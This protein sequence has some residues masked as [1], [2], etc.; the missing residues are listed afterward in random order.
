MA[1]SFMLIFITLEKKLCFVQCNAGM[2]GS[3][4]ALVYVSI[5]SCY[6]DHYY[7]CSC[8]LH[9]CVARLSCL[10][11]SWCI[12]IYEFAGAEL[13]PEQMS[14]HIVSL[15]FPPFASC[16]SF[17]K[18]RW[19]RVQSYIALRN[20]RMPFYVLLRYCISYIC[21]VFTFNMNFMSCCP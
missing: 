8:W 10:L 3:D 11:V 19:L 7:C 20:R 13:Q 15:F 4:I 18:V 2:D 16:Y 9:N 14:V 17:C 1:C 5:A 6:Y 12:I 21:V